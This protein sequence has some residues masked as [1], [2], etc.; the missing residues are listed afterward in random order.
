[1]QVKTVVPQHP[2]TKKHMPHDQL[3]TIIEPDVPKSGNTTLA[4]PASP[5]RTHSPRPNLTLAPPAPSAALFDNGQIEKIWKDVEERVLRLAGNSENFQRNLDIDEVLLTLESV[6]KSD[7]KAAEKHSS[8]KRV[9]ST[10]LKCIENVG[11]IVSN[12]VSYVS[13]PLSATITSKH[14]DKDP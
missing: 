5:P 11:S 14:T 2:K 4:A 3:P 13:N 9:F 1:M 8:I 7:E 10:T 6:K 12:G